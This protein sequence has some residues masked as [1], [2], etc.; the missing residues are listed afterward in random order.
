MM[1]S[2]ELISLSQAEA[3]QAH[4]REALEILED[5]FSSE[6]TDLTP[7]SGGLIWLLPVL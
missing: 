4:L 1:H 7:A 5:E 6:R 3:S 2:F